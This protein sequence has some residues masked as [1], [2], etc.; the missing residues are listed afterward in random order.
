MMVHSAGRGDEQKERT[1][2]AEIL[3]GVAQADICD[4]LLDAR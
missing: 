1:E 4:L 2:K 3:L